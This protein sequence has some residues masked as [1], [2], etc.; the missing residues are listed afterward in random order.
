MTLSINSFMDFPSGKYLPKKC[1]LEES[2]HHDKICMTVETT[3]S[4][5]N[6]KKGLT[7]YEFS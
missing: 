2:L 3:H 7:I 5:Y 4:V 1:I 6:T